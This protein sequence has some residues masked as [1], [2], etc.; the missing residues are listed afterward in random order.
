MPPPSPDTKLAALKSRGAANPSSDEVHDALF[1]TG[2]FFDRRDSVQVKYEMLRRV[3]V[4][5]WSVQ[6]AATTYGFSRPTFYAAQEGFA[7]GG[8]P[9]LLPL[10]RGPK[11]PRKLTDEVMVF[12]AGLRADDSSLDSAVM[13]S[14][15]E[16]RFGFPVHPRSLE[17]ALARVEKK[18]S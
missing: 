17:R 5:G 18:R 16:E 4:E 2:D 11:H 13:A 15:V 10:K 14:R 9:G 6:R 3:R 12:V 7:R 1:D 8:L